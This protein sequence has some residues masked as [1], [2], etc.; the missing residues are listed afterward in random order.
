MCNSV[1]IR[2][3]LWGNFFLVLNIL[4]C[5]LLSY[6][7]FVGMSRDKLKVKAR[8][9]STLYPKYSVWYSINNSKPI[10]H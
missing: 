9:D 2:G 3:K 5:V 7:N 8:E 6:S 1:H 10:D 4:F